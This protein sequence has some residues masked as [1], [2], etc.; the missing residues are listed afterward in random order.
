VVSSNVLMDWTVLANISS[1]KI[2]VKKSCFKKLRTNP[3]TQI[4]HSTLNDYS[5]LGATLLSLNTSIE[6]EPQ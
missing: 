2:Y 3:S 4:A 1:D 6:I 5:H